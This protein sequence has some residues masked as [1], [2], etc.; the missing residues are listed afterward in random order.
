[1]N[2]NS[3]RKGQIRVIYACNM[4]VTFNFPRFINVT[5]KY[6]RNEK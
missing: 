6:R 4:Y 3:D 5:Q 1:M 2:M